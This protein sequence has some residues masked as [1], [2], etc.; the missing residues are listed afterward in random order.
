MVVTP[1]LFGRSAYKLIGQG[2]QNAGSHLHDDQDSDEDRG[3]TGPSD[4]A[5]SLECPD[6]GKHGH[7]DGGQE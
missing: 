3:E 5:N 4:P 6:A 1:I 2:L 7:H